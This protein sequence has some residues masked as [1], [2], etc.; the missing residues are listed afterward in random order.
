M[1]LGLLTTHRQRLTQP[2][3]HH[4]EHLLWKFR[5]PQVPPSPSPCQTAPCKCPFRAAAGLFQGKEG[6]GGFDVASSPQSPFSPP[7]TPA[8]HH[9]AFYGGTLAVLMMRVNGSTS[10]SAMQGRCSRFV[11]SA[12]VEEPVNPMLKERCGTQAGGPRAPRRCRSLVSTR[13]TEPPPSRAP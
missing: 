10:H 9:T 12:S 7:N 6:R 3:M 4:A 13:S 11:G 2:F 5:M 1:L 8:S